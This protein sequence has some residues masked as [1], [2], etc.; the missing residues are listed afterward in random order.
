MSDSPV[1]AEGS[2][3]DKIALRNHL[4]TV[5][6]SRHPS[7]LAAASSALQDQALAL[8]RRRAAATIAAYVPSVR[9]PGG[10]GLPML[11][12]PLG[13]VLLPVLLP[14]G[15][16]DWAPFS[17]ALVPGRPGLREPP[18][19]RLGVDAIRSADL[20]LVPALAVDRRG[21]RLGRGGGSYDRALARLAPG[22]PLIVALLNED[23]LVE[24]VPA[25][26]H[27]R[28]VHGVLTPSGFH[29]VVS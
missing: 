23:E 13:R 21:M 19:A 24:K 17:G 29:P 12:A 26:P 6:R 4:L 16:L 22:A 3:A 8:V 27:D 10:P 15:D 25:E 11:L 1:E 28:P 14:D 7:E 9:E 2:R 18:G 20:V 5:R